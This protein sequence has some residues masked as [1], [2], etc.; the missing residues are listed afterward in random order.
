MQSLL[1]LVLLFGLLGS[2]K[3]QTLGQATSVQA[4]TQT[5]LNYGIATLDIELDQNSQVTLSAYASI[6]VSGGL[7]PGYNSLDFTGSVGVGFTLDISPAN[8]VVISAQLTT[9]S[10]TLAAIGLITGQ[11]TVGCLRFDS[12]SQTYTEIAAPSYDALENT[13]TVDLPVAGTYVFV[14]VNLNAV[15]P[16]FYNEIRTI[17]ADVNTTLNYTASASSTLILTIYTSSSAD[18]NTTFYTSNPT[19]SSPSGY[20]SADAYFDFNIS[21]QNDLQ[22]ILQFTYDANTITQA[23]IKESTLQFGYFDD[24]SGKWTFPGNANVNSNT[25]VITQSTTHF[26]TWG[27][28]G[29]STAS[30]IG[31]LIPLVVLII[32]LLL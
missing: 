11:V 20:I 18:L 32:G 17:E 22:A 25:K 13:I 16:T 31:V 4:N 29:T 9:P 28:F 6:S 19:S 14:V 12:N 24:T 27:A 26:S 30:S 7:P 15:I 23:G 3:A 8:A 2:S 21:S 5:N 1:C 10:L